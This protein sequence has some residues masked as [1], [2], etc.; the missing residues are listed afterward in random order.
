MNNQVKAKIQK[1]FFN[2]IATVKVNIDDFGYG[3]SKD[4]L[5]EKLN[6]G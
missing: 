5:F 6:R 3:V 4:Y 2:V 1:G